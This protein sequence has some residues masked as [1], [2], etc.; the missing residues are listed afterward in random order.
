MCLEGHSFQAWERAIWGHGQMGPRL[1]TSSNTGCNWRAGDVILPSVSNP[2]N[3]DS[4]NQ[5]VIQK[6]FLYLSMSLLP[7]GENAPETMEF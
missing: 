5:V 4:S 7:E 3:T 2:L 1:R 6:F